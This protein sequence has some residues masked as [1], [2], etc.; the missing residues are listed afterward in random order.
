MENTL[1]KSLEELLNVLA[2]DEEPLGLVYTDEEPGEGFSPKPSELPTRAKEEQNAID[3]PAVFQSF[4]CAMGHIRRARM[5]KTAAYFSGERFGCPGAAFWLGFNKPQTET[6]ISYVSTGIPGWSEGERYCES[7]EALR[8]IFVH[9]DPRPAPRTYCV[10]KPISLYADHEEPELV[11]FFSRPESLC[12]L[13]QLACFV[14]N[15]PEVV[16]SPWSSGCGSIAVWPLYYL[17]RGDNRAVLGGWDPS[18]RQFFKNDELSFTI[19]FTM[20]RDMLQRHRES[21]LSGEE[22]SKVRKKIAR[23]KKVW[24]ESQ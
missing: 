17:T 6:I 10:I 9:I 20:F 4:S 22:W 21:F 15:N 18:A 8:G 19:P 11:I 2:L 14:T 24:G 16:A 1:L 13:H 23:S 7:P 3:W 12:G 5:K